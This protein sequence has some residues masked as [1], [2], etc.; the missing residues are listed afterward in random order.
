MKDLKK[1]TFKEL[2]IE[3]KKT[4]DLWIKL[5]AEIKRRCKE[6]PVKSDCQKGTYNP[7]EK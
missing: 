4:Y 6:I 2:A 5:N 1:L 7:I 3:T